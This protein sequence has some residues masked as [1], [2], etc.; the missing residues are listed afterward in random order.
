MECTDPGSARI[1][2]TSGDLSQLAPSMTIGTQKRS[3]GM[4]LVVF[5]RSSLRS[6]PAQEGPVRRGAHGLDDGTIVEARQGLEPLEEFLVPRGA[7]RHGAAARGAVEDPEDIRRE[8]SFPGRDQLDLLQVGP[9]DPLDVAVR[10]LADDL[11]VG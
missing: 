2:G 6:L 8:G 4:E 9:A 7:L 5:I 11:G 1:D 3:P 10:P